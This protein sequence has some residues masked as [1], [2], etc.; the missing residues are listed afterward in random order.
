M[1]TSPT[2]VLNGYN[3]SKSLERIEDFRKQVLQE[4]YDQCTKPQQDLF[5]RIHPTGIRHMTPDKINPAILLCER[6]I[7]KNKTQ[8][9]TSD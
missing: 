6:T 5:D 8:N 4:L 7:E 1:I 2:Q 9:G 3:M